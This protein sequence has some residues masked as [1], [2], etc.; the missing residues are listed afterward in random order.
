MTYLPPT[1]STRHTLVNAND[2]NLSLAFIV[3]EDWVGIMLDDSMPSR[4][5][6]GY[7]CE[8]SDHFR[9]GRWCLEG[10]AVPLERNHARRLWSKRVEGAEWAG[11]IVWSP[12]HFPHEPEYITMVTLHPTP[13]SPEPL[14]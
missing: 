7:T 4:H 10:S 5:S 3:H 12:K 13:T 9:S 11:S 6:M 2:R 8:G 14:C 1:Y